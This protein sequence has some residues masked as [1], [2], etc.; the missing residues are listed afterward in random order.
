MWN[1]ISVN[2]YSKQATAF[3]R[4]RNYVAEKGNFRQMDRAQTYEF[5]LENNLSR[6]KVAEEPPEPGNI[7]EFFPK[8]TKGSGLKR[9]KKGRGLF[10]EAERQVGGD[11]GRGGGGAGSVRVE[12][13][14]DAP[15]SRL[16]KNTNMGMGIKTIMG[17]GVAT[18]LGVQKPITFAPFGRYF[19]NIHKLNDDIICLSR[20]SGGNVCDIKT[21]RVSEDLASLLRKIVN[22][23]KPTYKDIEKLSQADKAEYAN[24]ARRSQITGGDIEVPNVES[25]EDL[26]KFE[27][28]KGEILSGNDSKE[29]VKEF[30]VLII[31]LSNAGRL[32]KGQA[33][34]L[35]MDL[36]AMGY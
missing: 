34:E 23:G 31:K 26:N 24:I 21:R 35:L 16:P 32:P 27:I 20:K 3:A 29:L 4:D 8:A 6:Y 5:L 18:D 22:G 33:R 25:R 1:W 11:S 7:T 10:N 19:I 12:H 14:P 15:R 30:K 28:M 9:R 13:R 17:K 2:G 36:T